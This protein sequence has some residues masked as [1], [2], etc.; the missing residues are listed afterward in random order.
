MPSADARGRQMHLQV[1]RYGSPGRPRMTT[2]TGHS[3]RHLDAGDL[4]ALVDSAQRLAGLRAPDVLSARAAD[5]VR[6]MLDGPL[7]CV[8]TLEDRAL[9]VRAATGSR[10]PE[11][12]ALRIPVGRG[13]GGWAV[14]QEAVISVADYGREAATRDFVGVMVDAEGI[15]GAAGRAAVRLPGARS[16]RCSPGAAALAR[17]AT[18]RWACSWRPRDSSGRCWRPRSTASGAPRPRASRSAGAWRTELHDRV[19]PRLFAIGAAAQGALPSVAADAEAAGRAIRELLRALGPVPAERE[20]PLAVR[21]AIAAAGVRAELVVLGAAVAVDEPVL[22]VLCAVAGEAL[23]NAAKHADGATVLVTL[24]YGADDVELVVQDDGPGLPAE[25][26]AS[27]DGLRRGLVGWEAGARVDTAR[28]GR[29]F[30]L[31]SLGRRVA[32][33]AGELR[34][35]PNEDGGVTVRAT[36]PLREAAPCRP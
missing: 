29:R 12:A 9:V 33:L 23:L 14:E 13:I 11:V 34:V 22:H 2:S 32:A 31:A 16:A 19:V 15:R 17:S 1:G 30:G 27:G 20:L 8:T 6:H 36:V 28:S 4:R 5:R 7:V 24:A 18:A 35:G 3:P 26:V 21:A 25:L 10:T